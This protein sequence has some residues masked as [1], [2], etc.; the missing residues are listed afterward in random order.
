VNA[1]K[2]ADARLIGTIPHSRDRPLLTLTCAKGVRVRT[3]TKS[4]VSVRTL[5]SEDS[6][7]G[8]ATRV[9]DDESCTATPRVDRTDPAARWPSP[10]ADHRCLPMA[11]DPQTHVLAP[12]SQSR[13]SDTDADHRAR[14]WLAASRDSILAGSPS[15]IGPAL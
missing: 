12:A 9:H 15:P 6:G 8:C 13:L 2:R 11:Q 7:P 3:P 4:T 1:A 10:A 5:A 14:H